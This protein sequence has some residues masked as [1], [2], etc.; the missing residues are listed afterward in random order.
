MHVSPLQI[1][2]HLDVWL[3]VAAL[4]TE[5]L[6]HLVTEL[7]VL[8]L[9]LGLI[10]G[11]GCLDGSAK[12]GTIVSIDEHKEVV[13]VTLHVDRESVIP[14]DKRH[15]TQFLLPLGPLVA[16]HIVKRRHCVLLLPFVQEVDVGKGRV[17][18]VHLCLGTYD[19]FRVECGLDPQL[20]DV[21]GVV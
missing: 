1:R 4:N 9:S 21:V 11:N 5:K 15:V 7:F 8:S 14:A 12:L 18:A 19:V 20:P 16:E 6:V 10:S 17:Q 13:A 2:A 3:H